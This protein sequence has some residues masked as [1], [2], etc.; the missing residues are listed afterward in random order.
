MLAY[1]DEKEASD[2]QLDLQL[3][4]WQRERTKCKSLSFFTVQELLNNPK[5]Q[6]NWPPP[7]FFKKIDPGGSPPQDVCGM[8]MK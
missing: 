3:N 8:Y 7:N 5:R 6:L 1:H 2:L 4:A